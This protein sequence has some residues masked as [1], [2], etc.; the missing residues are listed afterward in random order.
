MTMRQAIRP[1]IQDAEQ[2]LSPLEQIRDQLYD[3]LLD[4]ARRVVENNGESAY[5]LD[6]LR[7]ASNGHHQATQMLRHLTDQ[8]AA[9]MWFD[10]ECRDAVEAAL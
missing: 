8:R 10:A 4:T 2:E 6:A 7:A 1:Y 9:E 5:L 3:V